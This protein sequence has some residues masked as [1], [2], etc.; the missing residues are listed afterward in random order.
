[1]TLSIH[2]FKSAARIGLAALGLSAGFALATAPA[3]AAEPQFSFSIQT[4]DGEINF[5]NGGVQSRQFRPQHDRRPVCLEERGLQRAVARQGFRDVDFLDWR[6]PRINAVGE[7]RG[8]TVSFDVNRCTG[9]VSN[10]E[11]LRRGGWD[12]HGWGHDGYG[13]HY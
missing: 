8:R 1:M 5:G 9:E 13:R 2:T 10:V 3:Q 11:R 7:F 6:G 4:P 12:R